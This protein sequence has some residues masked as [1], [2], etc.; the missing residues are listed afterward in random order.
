MDT[1]RILSSV[2]DDERVLSR[3]ILDLAG[4]SSSSG[5]SRFSYFLDERQQ[6]ICEAVLNRG[7]FSDSDYEFM[8]GYS[9]AVRKV[10]CF[11]GFGDAVPFS[12]VVFNYRE[13]DELKHRDF[14]G[15]LTSLNIK[16]EMLGDILVGKTR[17]CVFVINTVLQPVLD[18][19]RIGKVPVRIS[20][21]FCS[22]DI[23]EQR[24][25]QIKATVKSLRIDAVVSC[26][27]KLSREKAQELISTNGV[28]LNY[29]E[30]FDSSV[31]VVQ[32]DVFSLKGYGKFILREVGGI[33]KKERV[34]ITIDK[35]R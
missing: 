28:M 27:L 20:D 11:H 13:S 24:F 26:A 33:S 7:G 16:R 12:P 3:H 2:T 34:F 35:F 31:K 9:G 23:P 10:V 29:C 25:D 14:L 4:Q 22:S 18:I 8:G 30:T 17:T 21:D 5:R 32:D 15:A 6:I 19:S 1:L